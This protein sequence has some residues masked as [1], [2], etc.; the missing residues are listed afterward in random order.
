MLHD[1]VCEKGAILRS[2][3][4]F[5]CWV[6]HLFVS[7]VFFKFTPIRDFYWPRNYFITI[8]TPYLYSIIIRA[9]VKARKNNFKLF[10]HLN[11]HHQKNTLGPCSTYL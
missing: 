7:L 11:Y 9:I 4:C 1:T 2:T 8:C 6:V 5:N 3:T 10:F